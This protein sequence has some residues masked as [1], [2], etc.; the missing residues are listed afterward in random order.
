MHVKTG[1][2]RWI[3]P[4]LSFIV[5]FTYWKNKHK[6]NGISLILAVLVYILDTR[7]MFIKTSSI[8]LILPVLLYILQIGK[9]NVKTGSI[10]WI[11]P[12]LLYFLHIGK[13]N[14]KPTVLVDIDSFSISSTDWKD[15]H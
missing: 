11:L 12:V 14:I 1:S 7:K 2:I 10:R 5:H 15:V 13:I 8:W 4:V 6:T 9:I 3:L